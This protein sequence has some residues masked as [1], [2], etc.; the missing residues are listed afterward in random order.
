MA[1]DTSNAHLSE[2]GDVQRGRYI[3]GIVSQCFG[4]LVYAMCLGTICSTLTTADPGEAVFRTL[5]ERR[6]PSYSRVSGYSWFAVY[7]MLFYG[8]ELLQTP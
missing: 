4:S 6:L 1:I 8:V 5:S 7:S 2:S 3:M